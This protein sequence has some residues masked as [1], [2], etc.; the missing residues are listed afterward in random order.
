MESDAHLKLHPN[1]IPA[2]GQTRSGASLKPSKPFQQK[3]VALGGVCSWLQER[4]F[5]QGWR[6]QRRE[7]D[8]AGTVKNWA[9]REGGEQ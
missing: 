8:G 7:C 9:Q 5:Q 6:G 2:S 4:R 1:Q 3:E